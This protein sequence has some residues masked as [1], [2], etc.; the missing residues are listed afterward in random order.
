MDGVLL[1]VAQERT[2]VRQS[3]KQWSNLGVYVLRARK[4][5]ERLCGDLLA[6]HLRKCTLGKMERLSDRRVMELPTCG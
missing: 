3:N 6:I 4:C 1:T 2:S 5:C